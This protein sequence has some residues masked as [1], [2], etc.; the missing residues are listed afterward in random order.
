MNRL[1]ESIHHL[2]SLGEVFCKV[3]ALFRPSLL[4]I[5]DVKQEQVKLPSV[6]DKN[7]AAADTNGDG[8]DAEGVRVDGLI[9]V[10]PSLLMRS[11]NSISL[12]NDGRYRL[13]LSECHGYMSSTTATGRLDDGHFRGQTYAEASH[14]LFLPIPQFIVFDVD[15]KVRKRYHLCSRI[16]SLEILLQ[17][18]WIVRDEDVPM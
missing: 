9:F 13:T 7:T 11:Y 3:I 2:A 17:R 18:I 4:G 1:L 6:M 12:S 5:D 10:E 15:D 14:L 16:F 8:G